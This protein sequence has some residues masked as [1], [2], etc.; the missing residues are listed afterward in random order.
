MN[1][2]NEINTASLTAMRSKDRVTLNTLRAVKTAVT[3]LEKQGKTIDDDQ[4]VSVIKK[5][6]K[7]RRDAYDMF[8]KGGRTE[9]A[10]KEQEE[11][12]VL[13]QFLPE[14]VTEEFLHGF[15]IDKIAALGAT[16]MKDMGKVM[17]AV[18]SEF[19]Q[20]VDMQLASKLIKENLS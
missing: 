5:Q 8:S 18:R 4:I 3:V 16:T 10:E 13:T 17:G 11:I 20:R 1:L 19:G 12:G 2:L 6:I 7:Q 9:L 14:Q 15:L